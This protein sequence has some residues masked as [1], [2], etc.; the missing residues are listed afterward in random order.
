[1]FPESSSIKLW[2]RKT[3]QVTNRIEFE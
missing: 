2:C 3:T 1:V